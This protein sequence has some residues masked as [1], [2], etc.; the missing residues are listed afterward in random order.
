M[1][2]GITLPQGFNH[3]YR[4]WRPELAWSR[5]VELAQIAEHLGFESVWLSDHFHCFPDATED[6][7]FEP[8][9]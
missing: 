8:L 3:E 1:R 5:T 7:T 2:L 6:I 9:V 4:G